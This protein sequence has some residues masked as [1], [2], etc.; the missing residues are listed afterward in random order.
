MRV[1]IGNKKIGRNTTIFN[2][3]P[4]TSCPSKALGL[5]QLC[6]TSKC[7]ALKAERQ[8]P[9]VLPYR[10][11]QAFSWAMETA[12]TIAADIKSQSTKNTKFVRFNESGDFYGQDCVTKIKA[13][14]RLLPEYKLY[15]YTARKDLSFT[16]L[17]SNLC[18]NG[19]NWARGKM[20]KFTAV[21]I[22]DDSRPVCVGDCR[23]CGLCKTAKKLT[24]QIPMH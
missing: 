12:E 1:S 20:N 6:D 21:T 19:S 14:A 16:K 11:N 4:A 5:C 9:A 3:G 17:P 22:V 15:G 18:I 8:Y 23:I 24:I 2:M 7:Y 13:I 10:E